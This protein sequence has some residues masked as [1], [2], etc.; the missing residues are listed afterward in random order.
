MAGHDLGHLLERIEDAGAGLAVHER[1]VGDRRIRLER[2]LDVGGGHLG[3]LRVVD[4]RQLAAEHAADARDALAVGAVLRHEHVST[5]RYQ[6]TDRC[7]DRE[8]AAALERDALVRTGGGHD[9]QQAFADA[10]GDAVEIDVPGAPVVQHRLP[11]SERGRE[12]PRGEQ[13][14]FSCHRKAP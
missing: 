4:R 1:D 5:A 13:I 10:R 7:L 11:G 14:R 2:A 9:L 3:V 8:G 12:G 6:G